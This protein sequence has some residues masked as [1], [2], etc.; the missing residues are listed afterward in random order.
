[1]LQLHEGAERI[2]Q[3]TT[4]QWAERLMAMFA[5]PGTTQRGRLV[6]GVAEQLLSIISTF[7]STSAVTDALAEMPPPDVW[8]LPL[9]NGVARVN[10]APAVPAERAYPR[11]PPHHKF[12]INPDER[13]VVVML[14]AWIH[15][16]WLRVYREPRGFTD[17]NIPKWAQYPIEFA[18][19]VHTFLATEGGQ[20]HRASGAFNRNPAFH[21]HKERGVEAEDGKTY[22]TFVGEKI[23]L[24]S[25]GSGHIKHIGSYPS[26]G[27]RPV[28]LGDTFA[29]KGKHHSW[30]EWDG[31]LRRLFGL[32]VM[33]A[34]EVVPASYA[35]YQ[36]CVVNVSLCDP[37]CTSWDGPSAAM[38]PPDHRDTSW[39]N[40]ETD[41]ISLMG[42][43][44][45]AIEA[46]V[47]QLDKWRDVRFNRVALWTTEAPADVAGDDGGDGDNKR[48]STDGDSTGDSGT[49]ATAG[50][51]ISTGGTGT[52]GDVGGSNQSDDG[53]GAGSDDGRG[54]GDDD[55]PA[56][57]IDSD[58]TR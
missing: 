53:R 33:Q 26:G 7:T 54:A 43:V 41:R 4:R 27:A 31:R 10:A 42:P 58:S 8:A 40:L 21:V 20:C 55:E 37:D 2:A 28:L 19:L 9:S 52:H 32:G 13:A 36:N 57:N 17:P 22:F 3:C 12:N 46:F 34:L 29:C 1:M 30:S 15:A 47:T 49:A 38:A 11:L 6:N 56:G 23:G 24:K 14:E 35:K 45:R 18:K 48:A 39:W 25:P 50:D 51:D 5:T 44:R 16:R